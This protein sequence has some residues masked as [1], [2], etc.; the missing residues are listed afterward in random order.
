M[1]HLYGDFKEESGREGQSY[2]AAL[3]AS[4]SGMTK[5]RDISQLT[6]LLSPDHNTDRETETPVYQ[7]VRGI[8]KERSAALEVWRGELKKWIY[9]YLKLLTRLLN[10]VTFI[11]LI[12]YGRNIKWKGDHLEFRSGTL[13]NSINQGP[14]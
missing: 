7:E 10:A 4:Y 14:L 6:L 1:W 12:I 2:R 8:D 5:S 9:W 3:A 11:F 13:C